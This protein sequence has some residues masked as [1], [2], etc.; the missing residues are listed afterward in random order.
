MAT[1]DRFRRLDRDRWDVIVVGA[2][3]SGLTTA[4]LLAQRGL[5]VLLVDQHYVPGGN[6]TIFKRPGYEFDVGLHYIGQC[7]GG[8]FPRVL[9]AAGADPVRF[10]PMDPDAFDT[11]VL[12]KRE[13]GVQIGRA[14]V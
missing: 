11:V 3:I 10:R 5:G 8:L 1:P 9:A 4:A 12:P 13:I 2:G 14:H 6:A 7:E